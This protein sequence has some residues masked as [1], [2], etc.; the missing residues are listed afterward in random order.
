MNSFFGASKLASGLVP[1]DTNCE[2]GFRASV[3]LN[4]KI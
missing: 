3:F 2:E 4:L 1:C